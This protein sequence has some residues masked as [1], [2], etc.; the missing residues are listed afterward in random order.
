MIK[1][2][3]SVSAN[4]ATAT[5]R[6]MT[7][8]VHMLQ[9]GV[10]CVLAISLLGWL[11]T[12]SPLGARGLVAHPEA[13]Q[14]LWWAIPPLLLVVGYLGGWA[15]L[16]WCARPVRAW[17]HRMLLAHP[18][19]ALVGLLGC[20]VTL[21]PA[22]WTWPTGWFLLVGSLAVL[23]LGEGLALLW[24][25]LRGEAIKA[26]V[27][28]ALCAPARWIGGVPSAAFALGVLGTAFVLT[29]L[30]S[31]TVFRHRPFSADTTCQLQ[32]AE[33]FA[34]GRVVGDRAQLP[35]P[36]Q[37]TCL[38]ISERGWYAIQPP[39]HP[40]LLM[41]GVLG[42]APWIIN[43]LLGSLS[44]LL[45]YGLGRALY[46]EA[47]GRLAAVLAVGSPYV[48]LMSS[49][50][51]NHAT[52]L[53][54]FLLCAWQ[55]VRMAQTGRVRS[56]I[57]AGL[58]LGMVVVTRPLTALGL[59]APFLASAV[60]H[61]VTR[62]KTY[63]RAVLAMAVVVLAFVALYGAYNART[64]G[65]PWVSGYEARYGPGHNPGFHQ[66]SAGRI[67]TLQRGLDN[68][69]GEL[70]WLQVFAMGWPVPAL[71]LAAAPFLLNRERAGDRLLLASFIGLVVAY[72]F[73]GGANF[74]YFGP[75]FFY[76]GLGPLLVLMARGLREG[77]EAVNPPARVDAQ[78]LLTVL[79]A[80]C[81]I[82]AGTDHVP[83]VLG[84]FQHH[85]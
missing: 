1:A 42:N 8:T 35:S 22:S 29:N 4:T 52:A 13:L 3:A 34:Q 72:V 12:I 62:F 74:F 37:S 69:L 59:V 83:R 23:L 47:T 56:G 57:I 84:W 78:C 7:H 21:V 40:F 31:A 50:F 63:G 11:R 85:A 67:H 10:W 18:W 28:H 24:R 39:G 17:L 53:C 60:W 68:V 66:R 54:G 16:V 26:R 32:Q 27:R 81:L 73:Y 2:T 58:G 33:L 49:E 51:M 65:S 76:E 20:G 44:V 6:D 77:L 5:K 14:A 71:L 64:T 43:P 45:L 75:R 55:F 48:V 19:R 70:N 9:G 46:D 30:L 38:V 61:A 15:A 41:W 79:I 25:G 36:V 80:A 82:W